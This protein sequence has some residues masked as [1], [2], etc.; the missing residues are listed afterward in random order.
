MTVGRIGEG[1]ARELSRVLVE[2]IVVLW[3]HDRMR[4]ARPHYDADDSPTLPS[5]RLFLGTTFS[6]YSL[7]ASSKQHRQAVA[8]SI[9]RAF[10]PSG[11]RRTTWATRV[12]HLWVPHSSCCHLGGI[13]PLTFAFQVFFQ[14]SST[15]ST[16]NVLHRG[17]ELHI[18]PMI[19]SRQPSWYLIFPTF[20]RVPCPLERNFTRRKTRHWV[21]F[22]PPT[23]H[24]VCQKQNC[25]HYDNENSTAKPTPVPRRRNQRQCQ[26]AETN[27]SAM[28][29]FMSHSTQKLC[30]CLRGC[31]DGRARLKTFWR[32]SS[33]VSYCQRIWHSHLK[34]IPQN[35]PDVRQLHHDQFVGRALCLILPGKKSTA[36]TVHGRKHDERKHTG[37]L[38]FLSSTLSNQRP[39]RCHHMTRGV[40]YKFPEDDWLIDW[41]WGKM[42]KIR[43]RWL[44]DW[45]IDWL[46]VRKNGTNPQKMIDWLIDCEEKWYKS[47]EDDWLIDWLIVRKNGHHS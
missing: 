23:H 22:P 43:R 15:S 37:W 42:V 21:V 34:L 30:S 29:N 10:L 2:I 20:Q 45:L 19:K 35:Q 8:W 9:C 38:S 26:G 5:L 18:P 36:S 11:R 32:T 16:S 4:R 17:D 28:I 24:H 41:L 3:K 12:E 47:L 6:L 25:A 40:S 13:Q 27:A 1:D 31:V 44:I 46:I 14:T 39:S 33:R 7:D